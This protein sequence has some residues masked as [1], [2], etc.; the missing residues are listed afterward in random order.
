MKEILL[1]AKIIM[2]D[3]AQKFF[4]FPITS[5]YIRISLWLNGDKVSTFS[6]IRPF[7]TPINVNISSHVTVLI[8]EREF[9]KGRLTKEVE[10]KLGVYPEEIATGVILSINE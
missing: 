3:K 8:V 7:E 2:F 9:L 10:F 6:E 5:E 4:K 1:E